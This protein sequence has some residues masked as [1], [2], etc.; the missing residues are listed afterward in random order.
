MSSFLKKTILITGAANGIG[1]ELALKFD[2][3]SCHKLILVDIDQVGLNQLKAKLNTPTEI[4]KLDLSIN[5]SNDQE[6]LEMIN[7]NVID[8]VICNAGLGGIN[9]GDSF[10][11]E[12]N[13][14]MMSVN[15]FGTSSLVSLILPQM[16]KRRDGHIVGV[17]SLA[18]LRGMP[19]AASYSASKAA[20]ISFLESLR[21]DLRPYQIKVTTVLPGFIATKMTEHDD[22]KMPFMLSS[23]KTA[24][25]IITAIK[26]N[27]N[28]YY[29]PFPMNCLAL[30][31][32]FLPVFIYDR[33]IL[34]LNPA[35]KKQAKIF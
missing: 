35:K 19:Q 32:K 29:F 21:L 5:F 34:F 24:E 33:L 9:P 31:N 13:R 8:L 1:K 26:K 3:L 11:E 22:F 2:Q 15:F 14:K 30:F 20:Q 7:N 18:G 17:A 10:N 28:I 4:L 12:I 27:K 6:L 25:K 16:L 23:Q